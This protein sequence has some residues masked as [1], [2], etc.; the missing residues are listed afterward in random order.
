MKREYAAYPIE[1]N[2]PYWN[3]ASNY[4]PNENSYK[5]CL[6]INGQEGKGALIAVFPMNFR[7]KDV[8]AGHRNYDLNHVYFGIF[9]PKQE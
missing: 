6:R 8:L 4:P 3:K 2:G 5:K 7:F 9:R 1:F